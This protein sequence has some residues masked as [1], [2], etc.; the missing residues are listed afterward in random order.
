M[1]DFSMRWCE[2]T[3]RP[4]ETSLLQRS[5]ISIEKDAFLL[6]LQRSAMSEALENHLDVFS[7]KTL[8]TRIESKFDKIIYMAYNYFQF[9]YFQIFSFSGQI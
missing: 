1:P 6:A 3:F 4:K 2:T 5:N 8:H 7:V 9:A